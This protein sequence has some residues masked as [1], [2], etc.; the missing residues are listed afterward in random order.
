ML[1]L[2]ETLRKQ[3]VKLCDKAI[4]QCITI[5]QNIDDQWS[6][7]PPS[8]TI[9]FNPIVTDGGFTTVLLLYHV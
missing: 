4:A 2:L 1:K 5:V 8:V 3:L 7:P 9:G 6:N